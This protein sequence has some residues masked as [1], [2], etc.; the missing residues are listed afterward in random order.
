[1][2]CGQKRTALRSLLIATRPSAPARPPVAQPVSVAGILSAARAARLAAD[3]SRI[4]APS[5]ALATPV[6]L[7][8]LRN[9]PI[10]VRGAASGR[11]YDFS[12]HRPTQPIDRRDLP[13]LLGTGFF[14]RG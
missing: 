12:S 14:R 2:C 5:Q 7:H 3:P 11:Y 13:G 9:S 1:M 6:S 10:R 8:Y 4:S